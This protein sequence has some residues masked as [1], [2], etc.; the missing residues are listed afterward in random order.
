[1]CNVLCHSIK[2][3]RVHIDRVRVMECRGDSVGLKGFW[4]IYCGFGWPWGSHG[5]ARLRCEKSIK[6]VEWFVVMT[7][8]S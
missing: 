8:F 7:C 4:F 5:R 3:D 6:G 2:N 1:M